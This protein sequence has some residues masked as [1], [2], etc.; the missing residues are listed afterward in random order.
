MVG[1]YSEDAGAGKIYESAR[2][3]W[4][5]RASFPVEGSE[6]LENRGM[7]GTS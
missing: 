4:H 3:Q 2:L 7:L 5:C 1:V 6:T